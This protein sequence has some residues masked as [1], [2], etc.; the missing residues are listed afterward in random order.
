MAYIKFNNEVTCIKANIVTI[1]SNVVR[2]VTQEKPNVSGFYLYLDASM[3]HP[4]DNGEHAAYDTL[5]RI[6]DGWYELSNNGAVYVAP[7]PTIKFIANSGGILAGQTIQHVNDYADI[8][9]PDAV[10]NEN[11]EFVGWYPEVP[12]AGQI[13]CDKTFTAMFHYIPTLGDLKATKIRDMEA[14]KDMIISQG[15]DATLSDGSIENFSL[16]GDDLVY[17]TALQTQVIAGVETIPWHVSDQ[18]IACKYYSNIDMGI[19]TQTAMSLL[20]YHITYLKDLTR[21]I[22][23]VETKEQLEDIQYGMILP[24]EYQSEPLQSMMAQINE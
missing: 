10:A 6:G 14:T 15:F 11:F 19:I 13:E 8:I 1:D 2:I 18:N 4:L 17:L 24:I 9:S 20:V 3:K 23:S 5:Y 7:V 21:Y 22:N 12:V 16:F